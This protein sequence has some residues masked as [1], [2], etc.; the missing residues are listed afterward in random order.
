MIFHLEDTKLKL[1]NLETWNGK[2]S[3]KLDIRSI[4]YIFVFV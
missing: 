2:T 3:Q 4:L 1:G